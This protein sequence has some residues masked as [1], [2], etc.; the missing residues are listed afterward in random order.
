MKTREER[1]AF[2]DSIRTKFG[3]EFDINESFPCVAELY[4]VMDEWVETGQ[5]VSGKIPF[6]E[7]PFGGRIIEYILTN[8]KHIKCQVNLPMADMKR[9]RKLYATGRGT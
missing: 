3:L 1:E 5:S 2:R 4:R 8:R 6:P 9:A 7:A